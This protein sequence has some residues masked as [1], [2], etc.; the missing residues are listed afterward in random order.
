MVITIFFKLIFE[1]DISF[2]LKKIN[3]L[4]MYHV[5]IIIVTQNINCYIN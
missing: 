3:K 5:F 2:S 4:S 1:D